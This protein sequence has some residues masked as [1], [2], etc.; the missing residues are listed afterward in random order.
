VPVYYNGYNSRVFVNHLA[1]RAVVVHAGYICVHK[2]ENV[3]GE[4]SVVA[5]K[6]RGSGVIF[7]STK[8]G[9]Y[10]I[11]AAHVVPNK[12]NTIKYRCS[13]SRV[14]IER[15]SLSDKSIATYEAKVLNLNKK[16]DVA[17]LKIK[18]NLKVNTRLAKTIRRGD[19]VHSLGFPVVLANMKKLY[20]KYTRGVVAVASMQVY[21]HDYV[22][23]TAIIFFGNSGGALYNDAGEIVCLATVMYRWYKLEYYGPSAKTIRKFI[24][25]SGYKK[26]LR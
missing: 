20:F 11:T 5:K 14:Y 1:K 16:A 22:N 18:A 2:D 4:K 21:K 12:V 15:R 7:K 19:R 24:I 13:L 10:I 23:F 25:K 26:L 9:T 3:F 8:K 17:L 6:A